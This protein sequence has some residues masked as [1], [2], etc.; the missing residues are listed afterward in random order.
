MITCRYPKVMLK[1]DMPRPLGNPRQFFVLTFWP[2]MGHLL[3]AQKTWFWQKHEI[4]FT[5]KIKAHMSKN[6]RYDRKRTEKLY[7]SSRDC[8]MS[9]R[10]FWRSDLGIWSF[11]FGFWI[12]DFGV[13]IWNFVCFGFRTLEFLDFGIRDFGTLLSLLSEGQPWRKVG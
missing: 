5:S 10:W 7:M 2:V 11:D 1:K 6:G 4:S 9:C 8:L 13:W 12:L 3:N